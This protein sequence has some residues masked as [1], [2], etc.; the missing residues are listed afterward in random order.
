MQ[1]HKRVGIQWEGNESQEQESLRV[2][3]LKLK[4][5]MI[6]ESFSGERQPQLT[7]LSIAKRGKAKQK[8]SQSTF[9]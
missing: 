1:E 3:T 2:Q 5:Y 8:I 7:E 4:E 9:R 6:M